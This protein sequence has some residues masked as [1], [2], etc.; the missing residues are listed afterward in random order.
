M[1]GKKKTSKPKTPIVRF[2]PSPTGL[3]HIG[4]LR[5]ALFNWLFAKARGGTFIL[6]FD[7]TDLERSRE[8][9][10]EGIRT[11]LRWLGLAWDIEA[12]QSERFAK[13]AAAVETLR[14]AG[15]LYPCYETQEELER[16]RKRQLSRGAPP[17]YD[18]AAL[19]LTEEDRAKLEAEGRQPHW[20]FLLED[21]TVAWHDL[22]RGDQTIEASSLSDPVL[23]RADGSYLYTL[24][25][26]MDDIDF[27]ITHIIRGEDHVANTGV[28]IQLFETLGGRPPQFAHHSLLVSADGQAL[29][30]R[31]G[32]LSIQSFREEGLEPLAV[33]SH[34]ATVGTSHA[35]APYKSLTALAEL[36]EFDK[37]SR[38][39][40]RF[41]IEELRALNA[42][43]LQNLDYDDVAPRLAADGI[44]GGR[45]FWEAVRANLRRFAEAG[46]W[47]GV[48]EGPIDPVI[49]E[50][51]L[52]EVAR[53]VLPS[54]P[55]AATTWNEW[56]DAVKAETG[57]KGKALF[58]PLRLA[59]TGR[60]HGPEL[61]ALLPLIGRKKVAERLK[62]RRA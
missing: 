47:W 23:I 48:V 37:L 10:V 14:A 59:L 56:T 38:A 15:R 35:V 45:A 19:K 1:A 8:D 53:S 42:K 49:A 11:D 32:S 30:K 52:P 51:G 13:Y 57:A 4:N 17:V 39:P 41:D 44:G 55:W 18:R 6:R 16:R 60:E 61:K 62:G 28:Q 20:R 2:A 12:R 43:L 46:D 54:E 3:I 24:P 31:L 27:G 7:D 9:Y 36:F 5:T 21:R 34:S 33:L 40:A 26:V 50:G 29:S 22:I 58:Q 25:S